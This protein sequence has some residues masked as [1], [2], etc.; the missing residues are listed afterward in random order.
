MISF[1]SFFAVIL[2]KS[3]KSRPTFVVHNSLVIVFAYGAG[4]WDAVPSEVIF[5]IG[6]SIMA[7][8]AVRFNLLH[9]FIFLLPL[10]T[11]NN[12][13]CAAGFSM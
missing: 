10:F 7:L 9:L 1:S 2:H 13:R 5:F 3:C 8:E 6:M 12:K 11:L 4:S